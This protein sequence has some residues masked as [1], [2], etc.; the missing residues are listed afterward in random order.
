MLNDY[1]VDMGRNIAE[2]IEGNNGNHL[3]L[4]DLY[5]PTLGNLILFSSDQFIV[6][7]LKN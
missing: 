1:F 6:I 2:S 7:Q 5:K 3:D 4:R